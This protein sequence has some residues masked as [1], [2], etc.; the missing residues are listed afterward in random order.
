MARRGRSVI[1]RTNYW[2]ST[3]AAQL[4]PIRTRAIFVLG[5]PRTGTNWMCRIMGEYFRLPLYISEKRYAPTLAPAVHHLHRFV[6]PRE[7]TIYMVRDGRDCMVSYYF[8]LLSSVP[9]RSPLRRRLQERCPLPLSLE[10][11]RENLPAF[12]QFLFEENRAS[13][14]PYHLHVKAARQKALRTVRYEG[15]KADGERCVADAVAFLSSAPADPDRVRAAITE[16]SF[17]KRSG[18]VSG[19]E[20]QGHRTLRKGVVGDWRNYFTPEAAALFCSYAGQTL[21]EL[22]YEKDRSWVEEVRSARA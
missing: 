4:P 20:D 22:G 11:I 19:V 10:T 3:V 12:I 5:Y 6:V 15:L 16:T 14:I 17:E 1:E 8:K 13:S 2:V 7:R 9:E 18:R 21:I